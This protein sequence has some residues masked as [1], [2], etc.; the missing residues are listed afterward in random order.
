MLPE[1]RC[2]TD[3]Y[4][5]PKFDLGKKDINGFIQELKGFHEQFHECFS[6]QEPRDNFFQYM[7]GQLSQVERKSIEPI[8]LSVKNAKVRA[9]QFFVSDVT[10]NEKEVV[11]IYR[12]MVSEDMG[13]PDG[14]LIFDESGFVKKGN[15]SAGVARQYCGNIG[16]VENCQVGVFA[17]YASRH[18]YCFLGSRLFVPEKWF[19]GEYAER[20]ER[21]KFPKDIEFK[22]K[23][24]LAVELLREIVK[25]GQIPFRFV[26][27]DS[28]YGNSPDFT[29]AVDE[30]RGVTYLVSMPEDT[31]CWLKRPL[32]V[33]KEYRFKG[34]VRSRLLLKDAGKEP[35][36]FETIARNLNCFFW[37]RRKVSEGT[38][39]PVEYEFTKRRVVLSRAGLPGKEVWLIIRRTLDKSPVYSFFISNAGRSARLKLF[40][41]LSGIRWAIEQCFEE[42]KTELG[43]DHYEVRKFPGWIHHM[44]TCMLAHFFLWHIKLRLGKKS[45]SHY[46]IAA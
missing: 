5:I 9:M 23:P 38:K 2:E 41:W 21:C 10:W 6:R 26:V 24:R 27:A 44:M 7:V 29:E 25:D 31:L 20:R 46:S 14:A 33:K 4:Q 43:M 1:C 13:D 28:V 34:Q 19:T 39:G 36:S 12:S 45:T 22:T 42:T 3:P 11:S 30:L 32:V 18:G 37:Y 40:V 16:K 35:V 17:G 8:A 15:D